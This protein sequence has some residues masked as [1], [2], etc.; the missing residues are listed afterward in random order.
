MLEARLATHHGASQCLVFANP[1]WAL[2]LALGA[3][4]VPGR[5]EVVM[6]ALA[7][8]EAADFCA[9]AGLVPRFCDVDS[10]TLA[11]S[12]GAVEACLHGRTAAIL[13]SQRT[14]ADCD[15]EALTELARQRDVPVVID[16]S[17]VDRETLGGFDVGLLGDVALFSLQ[18]DALINGFEG[19]YLTTRHDEIARRL[20]FS[21]GFGF[22]GPDNVVDFGLNAKLN[23]VHAAM[24]LASLDAHDAAVA[25]RREARESW[26]RHLAAVPGV[27]LVEHDPRDSSPYQTVMVELLDAWP[28]SLDD[29]IKVVAAEGVP[30]RPYA[31][32]SRHTMPPFTALGAPLA[33]ADRAAGRL[34]L[35]EEGLQYRDSEIAAMGDVFM[36][37][38]LHGAAIEERMRA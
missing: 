5:S 22:F 7:R 13:V 33:V 16:A 21:R 10:T 19:A 36:I 11:M 37:V 23:E 35:F 20:T 3:L 15:L 31:A 34:M 8:R 30:A 26:R 24:A 25:R 32:A 4:A 2:T 28:L 27:R 6:S 17:E 14:V 1:W 18:S 12:V 29:T 38:S 9:R